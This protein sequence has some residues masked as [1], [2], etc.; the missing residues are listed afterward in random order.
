M[1]ILAVLLLCGCAAAPPAPAPPAPPPTFVDPGECAGD[2]GLSCYW[3]GRQLLESRQPEVA[4][5]SMEAVDKACAAGMDQACD[6]AELA[7]KA[8]RRTGGRNPRVPALVRDLHLRGT[9][10]VRCMLERDG[11][12]RDCV[13]LK[14][15]HDQMDAE[16]LDS[17]ATRTYEPATWGGH[18]VQVPID[19]RIDV[20]P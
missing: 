17:V 4:Q 16:V 12:L 9:V 19:L 8:P 1:R 7:F 6:L 20:N 2:G 13:I 3:K 18:P 10:V 14:G 5:E 15:L 11:R